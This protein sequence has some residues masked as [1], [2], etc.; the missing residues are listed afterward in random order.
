MLHASIIAV[1]KM[2]PVHIAAI[3]PHSVQFGMVEH[4]TEF[5]EFVFRLILLFKPFL[6]VEHV[7]KGIKVSTV[8]DETRHVNLCADKVAEITPRIKERRHH[9]EVH[10]W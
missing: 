2:L 7:L 3:F 5:L 10:K 9:Q 6:L 1:L 8:F 4:L